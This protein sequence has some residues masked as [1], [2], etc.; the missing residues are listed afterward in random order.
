MEHSDNT[1]QD[2]RSNGV[3]HGVAEVHLGKVAMES[4]PDGATGP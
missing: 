2:K 1:G 4:G 3:C